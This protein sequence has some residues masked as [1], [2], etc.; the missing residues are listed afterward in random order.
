VRIDSTPAVSSISP[1]STA[2]LTS[3]SR[4]GDVAHYQ[5]EALDTAG[6]HASQGWQSGA[7]TN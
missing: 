1:T 3:C 6:C 5:V 7:E 2:A 4:R